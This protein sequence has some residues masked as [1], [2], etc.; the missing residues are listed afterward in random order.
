M[1]LQRAWGMDDCEAAPSYS[2]PGELRQQLLGVLDE[3]AKLFA[4]FL[5]DDGSKA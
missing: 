5:V 2:G 3:L 1:S 4:D